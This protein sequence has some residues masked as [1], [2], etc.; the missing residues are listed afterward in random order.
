MKSIHVTKQFKT[1]GIII[2][3]HT[4]GIVPQRLTV[5]YSKD[6]GGFAT[7][8]FSDD[9]GTQIQVVVNGDFKLMMKELLK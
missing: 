1:D 2:G 9:K 4:V 6:P 3:P 7:V 5:R 8:S